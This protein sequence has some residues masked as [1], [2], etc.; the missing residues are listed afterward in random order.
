MLNPNDIVLFTRE[1]ATQLSGRV[2][3][4]DEWLKI[5]EW[6]TSDDTMWEV[7]DECIQNSIN[8]VITD[9][10]QQETSESN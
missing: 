4:E 3:T 10:D 5:R 1:E 9:E 7:I 6:I 2:L 8:E